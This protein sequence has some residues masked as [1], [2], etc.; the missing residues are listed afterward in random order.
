MKRKICYPYVLLALSLFGFLS[1]PNTLIDPWR[2]DLINFISPLW[3]KLPRMN[4]LLPRSVKTDFAKGSYQERIDE[5]KQRME[6]RFPTSQ[7]ARVIYRQPALWNSF[8]WINVGEK[9]GFPVQINSP[10]LV[11]RSLIGLVDFVGKR[12][13]RVRLITDPSLVIAVRAIRGSEQN[14]EIIYLIDQLFLEFFLLKES[15]FSREE[16]E[17]FLDQLDEMR[18]KLA[19]QT[20][21]FYLAKGE[22]FGTHS[23]LYRSLSSKLQG[24]GFNYDFGDERGPARELRSGKPYANLLQ[25]MRMT[26]IQE[27][28]LLVTSGLDG[29]LPEGIPVAVVSKVHPLREGEASFSI[30]AK[31][32][33]EK[34]HDL[35][36]VR[37]LPFTGVEIKKEKNRLLD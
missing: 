24:V 17:S 37:V 20:K 6:D 18:K 13:S 35:S 21:T 31:L 26:L 8:V 14:R 10:V 3:E 23:S 12:C 15:L 33:S 5:I 7:V 4:I 11:D 34:M 16:K 32:H 9:Q 25:K 29:V 22:I 36:V 1:V 28:D 30:E 27:G 19:S 2:E